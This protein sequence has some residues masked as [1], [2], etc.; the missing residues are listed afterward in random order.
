MAISLHSKSPLNNIVKLLN[1]GL[2][3]YQYS[4]Y[5][6]QFQKK[7]KQFA[8]ADGVESYW[9]PKKISSKT[10]FDIGSITKTLLTTSVL[11]RLVDKNA[12]SISDT[13]DKFLPNFPKEF[14]KNCQIKH[15][16]THSS[17][18][19]G[20]APLYHS[21]EKNFEKWFIKNYKKIRP[22]KAGVKTEYSDIGFLVLGEVLKTFGSLETLLK[23]EVAGPL[24]LFQTQFCPSK[25][26]SI[27]ATEFSL[28]ENKLIHKVVFD[29]NSRHLGGK[30]SHAGLFSTSSN[31]KRWIFECLKAYEG[32]SKWLSKKT[33]TLFFTRQSL[34]PKSTW[35]LGFDTPSQ[36]NSTS[37]KNFSKK[38]IGTLGYPGCSIW[39]DLEKETFVI[40][41]TNRIH[42]TRY[43]ERFR[44]L[45]PQ[46][47]DEVVKFLNNYEK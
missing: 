24:K 14:T 15:L 5:Q 45:R 35:A 43:D 44:K 7:K 3:E 10:L 9:T 42:P 26:L 33:A 37:G 27:A 31:L 38:S 1:R 8:F 11:A 40:L 20:W 18:L 30:T 21:K 29:E 46:I 22:Y 25:K 6:L 12:L 2:E 39:C 23:K 28:E 19:I 13:L 32:Q 36:K 47:H 41:L 16:L 17:G 34:V 4:C